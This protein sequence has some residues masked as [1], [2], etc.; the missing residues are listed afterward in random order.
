M[1]TVQYG[2]RLGNNMLQY[3]T[4]YIFAK[5]YGYVLETPASYGN[6]WNWPTPNSHYF[7]DYGKYFN[8]NPNTGTRVFKEPDYNWLIVNENNL[9]EL[10]SKETIPPAHYVFDGWFQM[11]D[12][13][14]KYRNELKQVYNPVYRE[15]DPD[16]MF[17]SVRLG[18]IIGRPAVLPVEY[19]IDAISR[20]KYSKGYISSD[21]MDHPLVTFLTDKF[22]LIQ[23][24]N[25]DPLVKL[26]FAKDFN[27]LVLSEGTY[28]W[29]MGA[30]SNAKTVICNNRHAN[31]KV[32]WHGDIFVYPDWIKLCYDII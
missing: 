11:P 13:A 26:D 24:D 12:L 29:W 5:K 14:L 15:R 8:V 32:I 4:G 21:T 2:G 1:V 18:D 23:W 28:C 19:Y 7:N 6:D 9:M 25:K 30:L 10:L 16:E 3:A 31:K 27:Q 17:V 22:N 20:L